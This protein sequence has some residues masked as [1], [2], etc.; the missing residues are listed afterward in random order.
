LA[1]IWDRDPT[2]ARAV[3]GGI[4]GDLGA[5]DMTAKQLR[6]T[7]EGIKDAQ[8]VVGDY[9]GA[10][11]KAYDKTTTYLDRL[12]TSWAKLMD[13]IERGVEDIARWSAPAGDALLWLID[14]A[15]DLATEFQALALGITAAGVTG[16]VLSGL[17]AA[18]GALGISIGIASAPIWLVVG[19]IG[20]VVAGGYWLIKNWDMVSAESERIWGGIRDYAVGAWATVE[21]ETAATVD[22]V[23]S[24]LASR[25]TAL[26]ESGRAFLDSFVEGVKS[27]AGDL[28][29]A[30]KET[31]AKARDLLPF[32][33]AKEGPLSDL[34][35]SGRRL[36][37]T[38]ATGIGSAGPNALGGPLSGILG[39]ALAALEPGTGRR[40]DLGGNFG[41]AGSGHT[42]TVNMPINVDARGSGQDQDIGAAV[43]NTIR[44]RSTELVLELERAL[45]EVWARQAYRTVA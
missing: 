35:L 25:G 38:L 31:L 20:A 40:L 15:A 23:I 28:Y 32:S 29:D 44:G 33:D 45:E 10:T 14:G 2:A 1:D 39:G 26:Y 6:M 16:G 27:K 11:A 41:G 36:V 30:V 13:P 7:G 3:I 19:A 5:E 12:K 42:I 4:S 34:T 22:R 8:K 9:Q 43:V 21:T 17:S 37:E 18:L 24:Y